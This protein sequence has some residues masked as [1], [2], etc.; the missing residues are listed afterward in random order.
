MEQTVY[1]RK[2]N[3]R[4]IPAILEIEQEC[5]REDSFSREQ[6]AYLIGR[7]K[8]I[9]YVVVEQ[10]QI[11]A[12][13]SLLLHAGTRYLRIY[14]IAVHPDFR[15]KGLGQALMDQTIRTADECKAAKITLEVKVTNAAAIALYMKNG[16]IP[17]GIKP[18]YYH[19]GSDA[20][21]M[22]RLIP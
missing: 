10:E 16:F 7:S 3:L 8:G 20:I 18:C 5:F 22:Q 2:A 1:L 9:F 6:F 13:I 21:Y 11:I 14:S 17:A 12:Y 15:G 19:D 4:D